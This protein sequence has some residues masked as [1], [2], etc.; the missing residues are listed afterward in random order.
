[1]GNRAFMGRAEGSEACVNLCA[2]KGRFILFPGEMMY[3]IGSGGLPGT[4]HIFLSFIQ[5]LLLRILPPGPLSARNSSPACLHERDGYS[6]TS[7]QM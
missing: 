7:R 2:P 3:Y 1:M 6:N 5:T 4:V